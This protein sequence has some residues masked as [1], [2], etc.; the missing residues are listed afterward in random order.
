M[1]TQEQ[2]DDLKQR[3][4]AL[5][6]EFAPASDKRRATEKLEALLEERL[7]VASP[8]A[9]EAAGEALEKI[10]QRENEELQDL[11]LDRAQQLQHQQAEIDRLRDALAAAQ[12]QQPAPVP[13]TTG[14]AP[15]AGT[16][17]PA[18]AGT[19]G[20]SNGQGTSEQASGGSDQSGT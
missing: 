2:H 1:V 5:L 16:D 3:L 17:D 14:D 13:P 9:D 10:L 20:E 7:L 15:Q 4:T 6:I 18:R 8:P 11:L 12:Q 19:G